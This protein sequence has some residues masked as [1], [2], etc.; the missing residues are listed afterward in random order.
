LE[1]IKLVKE[2]VSIPVVANGTIWS[3]KDT[4]EA[5]KLT[6]VDGV[7]SAR[8]LL[9]N[10]AVFAGYETVPIECIRDWVETAVKMGAPFFFIHNHLMFMLFGVHGK[11]EKSEFNTLSTVGGIVDWLRDNGLWNE[12]KGSKR[13]NHNG[14]EE[15]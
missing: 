13:N 3:E 10:P 7:M 2:T 1:G 12:K 4:I 6:G 5:K 8:A 14:K 15:L 9:Q 11:S